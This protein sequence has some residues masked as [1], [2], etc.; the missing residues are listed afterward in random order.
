MLEMIEKTHTAI[1]MII[2]AIVVI[3]MTIKIIAAIVLEYSSP[4]GPNSSV[5]KNPNPWLFEW[6]LI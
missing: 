2:V 1:G 5:N 4:S 6:V 3:A